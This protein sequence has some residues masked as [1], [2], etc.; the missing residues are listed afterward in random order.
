MHLSNL[1]WPVVEALDK[2]TPVIMISSADPVVTRPR[3]LAAGAVGFMQK[4]LD[5]ATLVRLAKEQIAKIAALA[6]A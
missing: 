5:K 1:T 3:A 4:P 6:A 2:D